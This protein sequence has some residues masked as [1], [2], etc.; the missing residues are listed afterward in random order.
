MKS[1]DKPQI[2]PELLQTLYHQEHHSYTRLLIFLGLYSTSAIA[3][4]HLSQILPG[5]WI[6]LVGIPFYLIAA[7]SLHGISLFTHE[8]VHGVLDRNP[9]INRFLS[10]ACALPVGQ[11]FS[12]Y[13]VLH[14]KHHQHLGD[15]GDPD[16]YKNYTR[17][18]GLVFLMYWGRLI[19]GYPVYL[20]AI[21]ILGWLQGNAKERFW[22]VLEVLLL[23][24]GV[25]GA[26][27][28]PIPS[29]FWVH[30]WLIPMLAINVMVNIRGMSQHTLLEPETDIIRGTRTILTSPLVRFFMCNENYH[31]E[32]HLY[33]AVPWYHLPQLHAAL[34]AE[35][36]RRGA[37]YI[38]SYFSFVR[39]FAIASLT[40]TTTGSVAILPKA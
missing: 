19:I 13:Q 7:A 32:H 14:L 2:A 36:E 35:L 24:L 39:D 17:Q 9:H 25:I 5:F 33:P 30:G 38:P 10:I 12:A 34:K 6:Y 31:L 28:S 8:G 37:P 23:G 18:P 20:V 27:L 1:L 21:P 16:R 11:N 3:V 22:I 4:F 29:A 26:I 15:E 40:Q